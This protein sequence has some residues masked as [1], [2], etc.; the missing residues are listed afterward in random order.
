MKAILHR[1][2]KDRC[3][4]RQHDK[5]KNKYKLRIRFSAT[6]KNLSLSCRRMRHL[7]FALFNRIT[8]STS[9]RRNKDAMKYKSWVHKKNSSNYKLKTTNYNTSTWLRSKSSN[10]S[11]FRIK[12]VLPSFTKTSAGLKR[13]LKL[14]L[15]SKP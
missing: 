11:L 12:F 6:S 1:Q 2:I 5:L 8:F 3:F 9:V 4:L 14:L 13:E 10:W 7:L 15:I